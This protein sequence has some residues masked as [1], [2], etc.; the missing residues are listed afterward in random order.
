MK[1]YNRETK[2]KNKIKSTFPVS[3]KAAN[4]TKLHI[5]E[6]KLKYKSKLYFPY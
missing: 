3:K 5:R 4:L 6:V 2:T 1:P